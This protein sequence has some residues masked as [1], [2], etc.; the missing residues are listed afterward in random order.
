MTPIWFGLGLVLLVAALWVLR[1]KL[2]TRNDSTSEASPDGKAPEP[3]PKDET[4]ATAEKTNVLEGLTGDVEGRVYF[5][6][7]KR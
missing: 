1:A 7:R 5:V 6:A 2:Q 3:S 4:P